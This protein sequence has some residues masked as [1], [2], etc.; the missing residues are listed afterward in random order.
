MPVTRP[1]TTEPAAARPSAK[2][3]GKGKGKAPNNPR[4]G[5]VLSQNQPSASPGAGPG[6]GGR[7]GAGNGST[8][9][10]SQ[11]ASR[12]ASAFANPGSSIPNDLPAAPVNRAQKFKKKR[13]GATQQLQETRPN[14]Q[15][16]SSAPLGLGTST[17]DSL[18]SGQR[19][20]GR[21]PGN[22]PK[23]H[24]GRKGPQQQRQQA[25]SNPIEIPVGS[26]VPSTVTTAPAPLSTSAPAFVPASGSNP[27][28]TSAP[29]RGNG[30]KKK[31]ARGRGGGG[32]TRG[33]AS[34]AGNRGSNAGGSRGYGGGGGS[35]GG[36]YI[37]ASWVPGVGEQWDYPDWYDPNCGFTMSDY[38]MD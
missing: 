22:A 15:A 26:E 29:T 6:T 27:P 36:F 9:A 19:G 3:K 16:V 10:A 5:V 23:N 20:R 32:A 24:Q 17:I 4:N 28:S 13:G 1:A 21:A 8:I 30:K 33:T 14:P 7:K 11:G 35:G 18:P 12:P 2:S 34:R 25:P 37:G 38:D 31:N